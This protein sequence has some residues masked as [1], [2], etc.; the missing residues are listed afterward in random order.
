MFTQLEVISG[1]IHQMVSP[2]NTVASD[3]ISN[4]E[5]K[6]LMDLEGLKSK[7]I[8]TQVLSNAY[9]IVFKSYAISCAVW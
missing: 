4:L 2:P 3:S 6:L 7:A 9:L 1:M 5:I 8:L